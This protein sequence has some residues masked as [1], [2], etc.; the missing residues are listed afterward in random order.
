MS[1][2]LEPC[3]RSSCACGSVVLETFGPPIVAAA[4]HCADCQVAGR[5]I[6]VLAGPARVLDSNGGTAFLLFRLTSPPFLLARSRTA[7]E[8]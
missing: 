8:L 1:T 6:E 2:L 4:C 3:F 5:Q 7:T